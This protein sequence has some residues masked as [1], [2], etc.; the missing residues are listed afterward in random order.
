[1]ATSLDINQTDLFSYCLTL[2][3]GDAFTSVQET[4][5]VE[6]H[7]SRAVNCLMVREY[8]TDGRPHYHSLLQVKSPKT[9]NAITK[10]LERV[11]ERLKL[12]WVPKVSVC[13]KKMT[14]MTGQFHYLLKDLK[15]DKP[16]LLVGW[17]YTWIKQQCED[18]IKT[19]PL[20]LLK[21]ETYMVQKNTS[22]ELVLKFATA[23]GIRI[24][25]K[26]SFLDVV[27]QMQHKGFQF[28]NIKRACLYTNVMAR[29]GCYQAARS[30]WEMDLNAYD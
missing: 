24:T 5:F 28:D 6:W 19:I 8:H 16:L 3:S 21:G 13:V 26:D 10:N 2:T 17:K 7:R 1:M 25:C 30:V 23:T 27:I 9:A 4:A 15:G 11:Y 18:S 29:V 22:V 14:N 20:K 12:R